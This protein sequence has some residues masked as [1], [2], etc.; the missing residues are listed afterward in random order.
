M[1][2]RT[3][4]VYL[5]AL[6]VS[7]TAWLAVYSESFGPLPEAAVPVVTWL[8]PF[9]VA[10]FGCYSLANIAISL[11]QLRECPEAAAELQMQIKSALQDLRSRGLGDV[12]EASS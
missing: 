10:C 1:A 7:G 3:G 2:T 9:A 8:P 6:L 4:P 12:L 11:V 5:A